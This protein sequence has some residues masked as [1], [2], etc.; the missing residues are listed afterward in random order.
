[1]LR[2]RYYLLLVFLLGSFFITIESGL[3]KEK[4]K[5]KSIEFENNQAFED[6]RLRKLM[7]SSPNK[8]PVSIFSSSEYIPDLFADDL[9]NVIDFYHNHGYLQAVVVDTQ[10]TFNK[11]KKEVKIKIFVEE[12]ELTR[13]EGVEFFGNIFFNDSLLAQKSNLKI[14]EAF[15]R[16]KVNDVEL[17][18][19]TMYADNGYLEAEIETEI[20]IIEET[21]RAIIDFNINEKSQFKIGEIKLSGLEKTDKKVVKHELLFSEGEIIKYS[22][23]LETQR[24]LYLTGLFQSVFIRPENNASSDSSTKNILVELEEKDYGEFNVSF[25]YGTLD[26]I[27]GQAEIYYSNLAGT[28][29]KVALVTRASF[30]RRYVEA[31]FTEP[32]TVGLPWRTDINAFLEFREDPGFDLSSVGGKITFGR[33]IGKNIRT[34]ISYRHENANIKNIKV[35]PLPSDV[36]TNIRSLIFSSIYDSRNNLFDPSRGLFLE[37]KNEIAGA[38][39]RSSSS[40]FRSTIEAKYFHPLSKSAVLATAMKI[41]WINILGGA[42]EIPLNEKFYAGG[43]ETLRAFDFQKVGPLGENNIPIGGKFQLVLNAFELRQSIYKWIGMV[44]FLD[45]GNVWTDSEQF[46]FSDLRLSPGMGVRLSTPIGLARVD[47][48]FNVKPKPREPRSN[49]YFSMGQAF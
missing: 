32:R 4:Y 16:V 10:L 7:I 38:F 33:N 35:T 3:A 1:M 6:G 44:A 13:I 17:L 18:I 30:I 19:L 25:G 41:G 27:R 11:K 20:R 42:K 43:P 8:F 39:L 46:D 14:G 34:S 24:R 37:W 21:H 28:G 40:F 9:K 23:L 22:K 36:K 29:R 15:K 47:I 12:G 45:V 49:I 5:V 26:K 48:G 31:S 2:H